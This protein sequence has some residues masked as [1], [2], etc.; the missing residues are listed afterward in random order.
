MNSITRSPSCWCM[1]IPQSAIRH[2]P[3]PDNDTH[4]DTKDIFLP[5]RDPRTNK[6]TDV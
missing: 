4:G 2:E 6:R 5:A 1:L 3:K